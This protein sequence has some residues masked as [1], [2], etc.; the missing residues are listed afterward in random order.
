MGWVTICSHRAELVRFCPRKCRV[1]WRS[2][3]L[4]YPS[5]DVPAF[6]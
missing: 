1:A 6:P 3:E 4:A 5:H 2:L